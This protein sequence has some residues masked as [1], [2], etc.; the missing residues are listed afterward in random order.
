MKA[1][2][3]YIDPGRGPGWYRVEIKI[4]TITF[5]VVDNTS[6]IDDKEETQKIADE[7]NKELINISR[8]KM[9]N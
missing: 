2:V 5:N 6:F 7:V 3:K 9:E 8:N 1:V 4:G